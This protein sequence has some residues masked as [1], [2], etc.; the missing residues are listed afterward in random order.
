[1]T[2]PTAQPEPVAQPVPV[3]V[4]D[5]RPGDRIPALTVTVGAAQLFFF[6]AATYNGHRIHYDRA[7]A[8]QVE[9]H[10]DV[11][12]QGYL[13]AALLARA[14]TDWMGGA[15]QLLRFSTQNRGAAY[16]DETLTFSGTVS[17]VRPDGVRLVVDLDLRGENADG[18][19]LMP[20]T[21]RVAF[22]IRPDAEGSRDA[23]RP[24]EVQPG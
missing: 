12:V 3:A 8:T 23:D 18:D 21:A 13:Q 9:G 2:E 20:G 14:V 24:R 17:G 5:L 16:V 6:S 22:P 10:R 7:W 15:G 19:L 1:V 4:T 11:V